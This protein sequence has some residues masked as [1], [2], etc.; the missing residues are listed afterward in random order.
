MKRN[1][2]NRIKK[3]AMATI[4]GV[5]NIVMA[6]PIYAATSGI[7]NL[8]LFN[9]TMNLLTAITAGITAIA[10]SIGLIFCIKS[11]IEWNAADEHERPGK[12]KNLIQTIICTVVVTAIP[13]TIT[14]ILH[15][16]S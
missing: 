2:S 15:F 11:G 16:Y 14:W 1:I 7:E 12:Q 6:S 8:P 5:I 13:G 9:G 3:V 10:G 4:A